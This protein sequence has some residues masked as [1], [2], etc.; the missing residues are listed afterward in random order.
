MLIRRLSFAALLLIT[1]VSCKKNPDLSR[2][3]SAFVVQTTRD[4]QADFRSFATYYISDTIFYVSNA[5]SQDTFIAGPAANAIV[6]EIKRQM[7][8]RGYT[9]IGRPNRPDI[10]LD[11]IA[12]RQ[13]NTGVVWPP[14]WWW[15]FPGGP[16]ICDFWG[17]WPVWNPMPPATFQYS[18]GDV[19]VEFF[20]VKNAPITGKLQYAW[21][22]QLSG[23]LSSTD[24]TNVN[25]TVTGI[26]E[27]FA[28]SPYIQK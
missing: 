20:D 16:V 23:V 18:V 15:G 22:A 11:V 5:A 25:R 12:V 1:V 10:L 17:C 27:A 2:L 28:Q 4:Q 26:Q 13:V 3:S 19:I 7:N 21:L 8:D 14:G 24:A 6:G 9:F